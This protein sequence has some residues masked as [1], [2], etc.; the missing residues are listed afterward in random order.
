MMI[1]QRMSDG[2]C[3]VKQKDAVEKNIVEIYKGG[4][5]KRNKIRVRE[6]QHIMSAATIY[7]RNLSSRNPNLLGIVGEGG[8]VWYTYSSGK[9]FPEADKYLSK[10]KAM[11]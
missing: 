1:V 10:A 4:K 3:R 8:G 7:G 9:N 6:G 11:V 2:T 5:L